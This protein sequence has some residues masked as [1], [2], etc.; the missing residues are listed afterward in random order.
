MSNITHELSKKAFRFFGF[1]PLMRVMNGRYI[2]IVLTKHIDF[3]RCTG[4][5]QYPSTLLLAK[6][7]LAR[8]PTGIAL[9]SFN[10][11]SSMYANSLNSPP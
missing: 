6:Y 11:L 4:E 9:C 7:M 10:E 8:L 5:M 3:R 1:F 2:G